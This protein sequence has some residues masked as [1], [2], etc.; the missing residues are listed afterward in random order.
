MCIR[1]S[2]NTELKSIILP[3]SLITHMAVLTVGTARG[4]LH[5]KTENTKFNKYLL[6]TI[7]VTESLKSD[8]AIALEKLK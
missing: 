7:N 8:I 1:D 4:I 5:S 3:V 2:I 6:P